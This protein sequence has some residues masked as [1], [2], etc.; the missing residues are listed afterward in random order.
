MNKQE[1]NIHL[2][3]KELHE[4]T[5]Y[6]TFSTKAS[7][8][9]APGSLVRPV[10][11]LGELQF[12]LHDWPYQVSCSSGEASA[13]VLK[14]MSIASQLKCIKFCLLLASLRNIILGKDLKVQKKHEKE[15]QE[16]SQVGFF[17]C[18]K[19]C[20]FLCSIFMAVSLLQK[21]WGL[22]KLLYQRFTK[23]QWLSGKTGQ[24]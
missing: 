3:F 19:L 14:V 6:M 5:Q 7:K 17:C 12:N 16:C 15:S 10:S 2:F 11:E 8:Y 20:V 21:G 1:N 13:L 23:N 22:I 18:F 9:C 4:I 24:Y